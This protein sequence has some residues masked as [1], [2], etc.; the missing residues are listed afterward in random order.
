MKSLGDRSRSSRRAD[1]SIPSLDAVTVL[2]ALFA[3]NFGV[4][5]F[6][7]ARWLAP[8]WATRKVSRRSPLE[9]PK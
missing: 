7:D 9:A 3:T 8:R 1:R 5:D 2:F 4:E 6:S